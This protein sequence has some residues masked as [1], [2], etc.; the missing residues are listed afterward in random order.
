MN[1]NYD[2]EAILASS[3]ASASAD[4]PSTMNDDDDCVIIGVAEVV[5]SPAP[6]TTNPRP[7]QTENPR[8]RK[9]SS[10]LSPTSSPASRKLRPHPTSA[11]IIAAV[12]AGNPF[13]EAS[14][15][16]STINH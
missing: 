4:V 6:A 3:T 5:Q 13:L 16:F 12:P 2:E 10:P 15:R 14:V 9:A 1:M 7:F 11:Q 8:K